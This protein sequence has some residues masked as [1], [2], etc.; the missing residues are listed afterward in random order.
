MPNIVHFEI[1][2]DDAERAKKFYTELFGWAVEQF[3]PG[4]EYWM[5][6]SQEG[7]GGG[8]MKRQHP[9]QKITDYF[10]VPSVQES[11]DKVQKLGGKVL[12]PKMAVPDMGYFVVCMDTEGNIFGLWEEDPK[13]K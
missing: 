5:I 13:A 6:N 1:P 2:V 8:M 4:M 10:G 7:I 11:A 3:S 12:V 9:D